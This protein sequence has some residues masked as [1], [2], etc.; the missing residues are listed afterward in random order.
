M[1]DWELE[2]QPGIRF[3]EGEPVRVIRTVRNDGSFPGFDK[4]DVLVEAGTC[5]EVRSYGYFLQTQVI[6]QV[7]FPE[8]NRV[9]GIRETELIRADLPWVPCTLYSLDKARLTKS[10]TIKGEPLASKGDLIEVKR[11]WRDLEDGSLTYE[12]ACGE[13]VFKLDAS[14]L[15]AVHDSL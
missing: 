13:Y 6:F 3:A 10:L 9:I 1:T 8:V 4:G 11:S 7:Y 5:G 12:V 14:V 2:R 15:E